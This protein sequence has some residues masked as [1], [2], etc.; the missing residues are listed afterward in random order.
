MII[1][2]SPLAILITVLASFIWQNVY[3]DPPTDCQAQYEVVPRSGD[4]DDGSNCTEP[5]C[6]GS[7]CMRIVATQPQMYV[8][9]FRRYS[10][11]G[12]QWIP[13]TYSY[14]A[15]YECNCLLKA[16]GCTC[17]QGTCGPLIEK[18]NYG[19]WTAQSCYP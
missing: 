16:G 10:P 11:S 6:G 5:P 19:Y 9:I 18:A 8:C 15:Y 4:W 17:N 2:K 12:C 3:S 7:G 13:Q 14:I 1:N